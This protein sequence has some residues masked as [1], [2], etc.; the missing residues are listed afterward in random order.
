MK[1][2]KYLL[3]PVI[4]SMASMAHA[5]IKTPPF[6]NEPVSYLQT[7]YVPY[8]ISGGHT[9]YCYTTDN[10]S[11]VFPQILFKHHGASQRLELGGG[12]TGGIVYLYDDSTPVKQPNYAYAPADPKGVAQIIFKKIGFP[13]PTVHV[14]CGIG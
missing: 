14:T 6:D 12:A 9:L 1:V 13:T 7:L 3:I 11:Q 2:L 4:F 5:T 8:D 10:S